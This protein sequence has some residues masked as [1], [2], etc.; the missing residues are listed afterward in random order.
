[1]HACIKHTVEKC[2]RGLASA[3]YCSRPISERYLIQLYI[4]NIQ[5]NN[6]QDCICV[7][8]TVTGGICRTN[9]RVS[10]NIRAAMF[11]ATSPNT[12][13]IYSDKLKKLS[14]V[15]K[16]FWYK[17]VNI[18]YMWGCKLDNNVR[19]PSCV[20][21]NHRVYSKIFVCGRKSSCVFGKPSPTAGYEQRTFIYL[22]TLKAQA[23][24]YWT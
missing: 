18:G 10:S 23:N 5:P 8:C 13:C 17:C 15:A 14:D 4:T 1:M 6:A 3:H 12:L 21:E 11:I 16:W 2:C 9:C 7:K 24:E 22:E 20:L 19:Q